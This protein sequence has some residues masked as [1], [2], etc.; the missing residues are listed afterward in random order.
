M[1]E[2][3]KFLCGWESFHGV[4]HAYLYATGTEFTAFGLQLS[5]GLNA[6]GAL[7][8]AAISMALGIYGWRRPAVR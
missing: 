7:V 5:P 4:M 1:K 8:G 6:A 2:L 3:A